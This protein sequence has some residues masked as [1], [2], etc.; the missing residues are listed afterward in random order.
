MRESATTFF[1]LVLNSP[2]VRMK[3]RTRS[4][5]SASI[6]SGVSATAKSGPV[7]RLTPR[8]VAWADSTTATSSVNGLT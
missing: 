6:F 5:P 3:S 1:A 2:I 8:S 7:A 4:S